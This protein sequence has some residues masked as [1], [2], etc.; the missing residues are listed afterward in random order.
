MT[1]KNKPFEY[2]G[3]IFDNE[4]DKPFMLHQ[5]YEKPGDTKQV[6]CAKCGRATL[7]VG[8]GRYYTVIRCPDCGHESCIHD[9]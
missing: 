8:Q 7:E 5:S 9:G 1:D 6:K 3:F 4:P 2:E